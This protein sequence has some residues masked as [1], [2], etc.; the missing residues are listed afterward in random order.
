MSQFY[1]SLPWVDTLLAQC[2]NIVSNVK[3]VGEGDYEPS[4]GTFLSTS[5]QCRPAECRDCI[6]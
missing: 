6:N 1:I 2:L 4:D 3:A 5:P